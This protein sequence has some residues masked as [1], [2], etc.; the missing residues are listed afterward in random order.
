MSQRDLVAELHGARIAAP[1]HVREQVRQIV[2]GAPAAAAPLHWRRILVV[3]VPAFAAIAAAVVITRP[4]R[5][6]TATPPSP[7]ELQA[8]HG[9]GASAK[10]FGGT[11]TA[12]GGGGRP[13]ARSRRGPRQ[14]LRRLPLAARQD[15]ERRLERGQACPRRSRRRS[16]ASRARCT[17]RRR[18]TRR[19]LT[20]PSGSRAPTSRRRSPG[21][22]LSGRSWANRSTFR[23]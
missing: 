23:I 18:P 12:T 9:D 21:S 7:V 16:A 15:A 13:R 2:A 20:S 11:A 3:A 14:P 8:Q 17:H 1:A 19:L 5:N 4:D 10:S 22:R 6:E